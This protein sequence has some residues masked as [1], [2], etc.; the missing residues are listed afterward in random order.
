MNWF[1]ALLWSRMEH[2]FSQCELRV[3]NRKLVQQGEKAAPLC[4]PVCNIGER[5]ESRA[6]PAGTSIHGE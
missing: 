6:P 5:Q 3:I 1:E 2:V 4:Y